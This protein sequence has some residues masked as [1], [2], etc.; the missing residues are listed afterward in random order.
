MNAKRLSGKTAIITG[1]SSGIG[2]A[3][4]LLFADEGANVVVADVTEKVKEGGAATIELIR[5][6]G[7]EAFFQQTDVSNSADIDRL[8]GNTVQTYGRLDILVNNAAIGVDKP[9][10][11][12]SEEEWDLVMGINAKGVFMACK[13]AIEQMLRQEIRGEA[14]G[15]I[16]NLSSQHGMI[17]APHNFAYG[18]GKSAVVYMTRQIAVDYAK[19][20][21]ICN[22]V[23]PGRVLTGKPIP[24]VD[25]IEYSQ[26]RTPWPRLGKPDDIARTALFLAGDEATYITG[27]NLMVD[28]GW[29]AG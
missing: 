5:E 3:I 13:R 20:H 9:I 22:A 1:A 24:E 15:R 2:R 12:T 6:K 27:V 8:V 21:I 14:R 23:A 19:D 18:V 26:S 28:G 17:C 16:I 10:L 4:S 11:D 7:G 29:M 25:S